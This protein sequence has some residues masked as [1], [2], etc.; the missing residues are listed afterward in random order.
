MTWQ[1]TN[2]LTARL[3]DRQAAL[4]RALITC[5]FLVFMYVHLPKY[6]CA[7]ASVAGVKM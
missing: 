4:R 5:K 7:S 6:M 1:R 2:K 3:S